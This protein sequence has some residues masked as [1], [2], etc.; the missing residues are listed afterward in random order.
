MLKYWQIRMNIL[1]I[2]II[3]FKEFSSL[4]N[5]KKCLPLHRFCKFAQ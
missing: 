3:K 4:H 2:S 5:Q 1:N